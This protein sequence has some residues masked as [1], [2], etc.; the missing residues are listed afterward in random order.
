MPFVQRCNCLW[1]ETVPRRDTPP[2]ESY[3]PT[4]AAENSKVGAGQRIVERASVGRW[5]FVQVGI[6]LAGPSLRTAAAHVRQ[7]CPRSGE[8]GC[9]R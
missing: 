8:A 2:K 7:V 5:F 3:P 1:D 4:S 6:D 9:G